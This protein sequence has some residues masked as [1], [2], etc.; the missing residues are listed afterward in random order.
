[1]TLYSKR[2]CRQARNLAKMIS[3]T[4]EVDFSNGLKRKSM[5]MTKCLQSLIRLKPCKASC[6]SEHY[7]KHEALKQVEAKI[8]ARKKSLKR[9][10]SSRIQRLADGGK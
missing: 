5:R 4:E 2:H 6:Q 8:D 3:E 1:M 10:L 7:E 9:F